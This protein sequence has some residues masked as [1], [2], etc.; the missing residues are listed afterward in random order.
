MEQ[1]EIFARNLEI[2]RKINGQ[3]IA[4]LAKDIDIP[5]STLQSVRMSGNTTLDT[6]VRIADGLQ[7]PLDSLI[8]D[9]NLAEKVDIVQHML[10][11]IEWF[12][13][14]STDEQDEVLLHFRRILEVLGF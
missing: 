1:H 9:Q 6:A 11:A 3:S 2:I 12:R 4:E 7:I 10:Q 14:L 5:K 13:G 8:R